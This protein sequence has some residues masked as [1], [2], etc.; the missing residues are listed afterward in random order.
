MKPIDH[1]HPDHRAEGDPEQQDLARRRNAPEQERRRPA[2]RGRQDLAGEPR[3]ERDEGCEECHAIS[4]GPAGLRPACARGRSDC[5]RVAAIYA[6]QS[7]PRLPSRRVEVAGEQRRDLPR[8]RRAVVRV[9]V[10]H[11]DVGVLG[12]GRDLADLRRPLRQLVARIEVA[13]SLGGRDPLGLPGLACSGRGSGPA[14]GPMSPRSPAGR[15][16]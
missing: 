16:S 1:D 3:T 14:P 7:R 12:L 9:A 11:E 6:R 4:I 8:V 13:E 10:V 15:C 2:E 5:G